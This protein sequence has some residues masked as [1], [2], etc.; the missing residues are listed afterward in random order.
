MQDGHEIISMAADPS[1]EVYYQSQEQPEQV[2][3]LG[4]TWLCWLGRSFSARTPTKGIGL[5][6]NLFM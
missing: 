6:R 4:L 5:L 1:R 3:W 2:N